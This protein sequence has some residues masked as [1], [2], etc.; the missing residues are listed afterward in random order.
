[1]PRALSER[2]YE[3]DRPFLFLQAKHA[4]RAISNDQQL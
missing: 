2:K 1:M 4:E 3:K